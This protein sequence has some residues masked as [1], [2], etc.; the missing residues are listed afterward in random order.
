M[1]E[2]KG[3]AVPDSASRSHLE[4]LSSAQQW[5]SRVSYALT[6][7]AAT[8]HPNNANRI[9]NLQ[10][11]S[12]HLSLFLKVAN[13]AVGCSHDQLHLLLTIFN[14][15]LISSYV[16]T[17]EDEDLLLKTIGA[18]DLARGSMS[19]AL[20]QVTKYSFRKCCPYALNFDTTMLRLAFCCK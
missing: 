7:L 13:L 2:P 4:V 19:G 20:C 14:G 18:A 8:I 1:H 16:L 11:L 12:Q 9:A 15:L 17:K 6:C 3:N 5:S 10:Y